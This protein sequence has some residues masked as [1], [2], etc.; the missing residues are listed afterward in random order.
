M[1]VT[2]S[3][4]TFNDRSGRLCTLSDITERRRADEALRKSRQDL[5]R[6]QEVGKIGS[7]RLDVRRNVLTWS[8]ENHRIFGVLSGT[9]LTYESFLEIVHPD[10]R[11]YVNSQWT[12]GLHGA[13][14]DIEHRLLVA[15][16]VKWVREKAY[17]EFDAAGELLGGF[18]IT[19][20][21]TERK[22]GEQELRESE[23]RLRISLEEKEVL[24]REIHHRVKNNLQVISSLLSLQANELQ[25]PDLR[26]VFRDMEQRVRSMALVHEQLYQ[27]VDLGRVE[28]AEYAKSLLTYLWRAHEA[29]AS[30]IKLN[31]NLETVLLTVNK[32]VPAGLILNELVTNALKHAF[33]DRTGEEV[34]VT[35]RRGPEGRVSLAVR[36]N[37]QG[38]PEEFDWKQTRSL[39]LRLVQMLAGQLHAALEVSSRGGTEFKITFALP[40]KE[41]RS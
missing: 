11:R 35:M 36:D 1:E 18:G 38:F 6:A 25:S 24:L 2:A 27:S 23:E 14:Y 17:L 26:P 13:P 8:D 16:Q 3:S 39:G 22:R 28:F 7:W 32:A 34:T 40:D 10:D 19:Q 4:I 33:S 41:E 12:A 29:T 5:D 15:G 9:P 30:N 20:D 37:G 21:I 31:L